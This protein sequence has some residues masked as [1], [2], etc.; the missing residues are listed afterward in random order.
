[1]V[2]SAASLHDFGAA[3]GDF[4]RAVHGIGTSRGEI[5]ASVPGIGRAELAA[6]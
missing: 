5:G 4:L 3:A 2:R 1:M 6:F